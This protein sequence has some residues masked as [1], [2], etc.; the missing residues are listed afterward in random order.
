V[1]VPVRINTPRLVLRSWRVHDAAALQPVLEANVEHLK[2]WIPASVWQPVP[3]GELGARLVEYAVDFEDD[4]CWRFGAF[5][6]DGARLLGGVSLF[7]RNPRERVAYGEA[8]R[9]EIGYWFRA[10]ETNRGLATEA[11]R[12]MVELAASLPGLTIAEIRC[13]ARNAPSAAVPRKLGF[14]LVEVLQVPPLWGGGPPVDLQVWVRP[15]A[16]R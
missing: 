13:D 3:L 15:L 6:S 5:S 11:S 8:D 16:T 4:R 7:P 1:Q 10:E 2:P 14:A 9:A 12:A